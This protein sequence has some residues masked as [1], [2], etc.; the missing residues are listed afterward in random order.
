MPAT[1]AGRTLERRQYHAAAAQYHGGTL[2]GTIRHSVVSPC[3]P[4][5]RPNGKEPCQR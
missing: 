3:M 4:T 1:G 5:P 2:F